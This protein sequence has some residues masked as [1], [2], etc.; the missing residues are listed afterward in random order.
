METVPVIATLLPRTGEILVM[1][2]SHLIGET[3]I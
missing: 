1:S 2:P 3:H